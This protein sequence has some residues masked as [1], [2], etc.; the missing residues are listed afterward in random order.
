[1]TLTLDQA[2]KIPGHQSD[3]RWDLPFLSASNPK[4]LK[5]AGLAHQAV[6][7]TLYPEVPGVSLCG[8][9]SIGC[10]KSCLKSSGRGAMHSTTDCR[11]RRAIRF[12]S[13]PARAVEQ[14]DN[15][16]RRWFTKISATGQ[17]MALRLNV[18]SELDWS[19]FEAGRWFLDRWHDRINLYDYTKNPDM[20]RLD[21]WRYHLTFSRT[22]RNWSDCL[23]WIDAG[24]PVAVVFGDT[25][26]WDYL[27]LP[28]QDATSHDFRFLA[29]PGYLQGLIALGKG[30]RDRTGFVVWS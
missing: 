5:T 13:D 18:L 29:R 7:L 27:G 14:I 1:M 20:D 3:G 23:K 30:K 6:G 19:S 21:R 8:F 12:L 24:K 22:E 16:A 25:L 2:L 11:V 10:G 15:E 17:E 26:P 4:L 9:R 28:V